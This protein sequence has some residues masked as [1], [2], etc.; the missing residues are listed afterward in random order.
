[1]N[2]GRVRKGGR[3]RGRGDFGDC[4][5][6][7]LGLTRYPSVPTYQYPH[8]GNTLACLVWRVCL[9]IVAPLACY[10]RLRF[11]QNRNPRVP[12]D[13]REPKTR[14]DNKRVPYGIQGKNTSNIKVNHRILIYRKKRVLSSVSQRITRMELAMSTGIGQ[15]RWDGSKHA[16]NKNKKRRSN[17]QPPLIEPPFRSLE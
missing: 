2:R 12:V 14:K 15:S 13:P 4:G 16:K 10:L 8:H 7:G 6:V 9:L 5:S 3:D 17:H 1:M 11:G